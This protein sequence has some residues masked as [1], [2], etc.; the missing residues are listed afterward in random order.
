MFLTKH[1]GRWAPHGGGS[2]ANICS[3]SLAVITVS[4]QG[5]WRGVFHFNQST[6]DE[7]TNLNFGVNSNILARIVLSNMNP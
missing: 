6:H 5:K 1:N 4:E 3:V 2:T 7:G